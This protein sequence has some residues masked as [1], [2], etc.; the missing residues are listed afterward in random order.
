[1]RRGRFRT[2]SAGT[3]CE[4]YMALRHFVECFDGASR[5]FVIVAG[6]ALLGLSVYIGLDVIGRKLLNIT[7]QGS[8][9]IG[10]YIMAAACA[11]GFSYTLAKRGHIRLNL[12]LPH[13]PRSLQGIANILAYAALAV[14]A[15][16]FLW[17]GGALF[18]ESWE[19]KAI[20]PTP[21]ETTLWIPQLLWVA[22]LAWFALHMTVYTVEITYLT[23]RGRIGELNQTFGLETVAVETSR[24]VQEAALEQRKRD[25]AR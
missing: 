3:G 18:L 6:W 12:I 19:L 4:D 5:F 10:G 23:L 8:D 9:E 7:L 16:M 11:F 15:Y 22:G 24:E 20:A 13:L 2:V 25:G 1:M 14:Y 17:R 21:L